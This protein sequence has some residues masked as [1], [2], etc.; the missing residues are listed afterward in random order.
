MGV[1]K[2]IS[3]EQLK[4]A[5]DRYQKDES[6]ESIAESM[7]ISMS[8]LRNRLRANNMP[9]RKNKV[10]KGVVTPENSNAPVVENTRKKRAVADPRLCGTCKRRISCKIGS[11]TRAGCYG[12]KDKPNYVKGN[13]QIRRIN[14]R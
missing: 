3:I 10:Y 9:L 5:Y 13:P 12:T 6:I 1:L 14:G 8:C 11:R 4:N 7:N 2:N